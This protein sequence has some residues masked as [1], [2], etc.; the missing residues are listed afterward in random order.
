METLVML[1]KDDKGLCP[2]CNEK[3]QYEKEWDRLYD[4]YDVNTPQG[5]MIVERLYN[6]D[7]PKYTCIKC[8]AVVYVKP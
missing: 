4:K 6:E 7:V 2:K 3:L 8:D 1:N 5:I